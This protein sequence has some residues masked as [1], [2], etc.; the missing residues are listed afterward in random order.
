MKETYKFYSVIPYN[1][2]FEFYA[3]DINIFI[4]DM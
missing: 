2:W 1:S 4:Y 3:E